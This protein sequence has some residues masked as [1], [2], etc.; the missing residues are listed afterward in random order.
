MLFDTLQMYCKWFIRGPRCRQYEA[1]PALAECVWIDGTGH[2]VY[3]RQRYIA[4]AA[5]HIFDMSFADNDA[6]SEPAAELYRHVFSRLERTLE[7]NQHTPLYLRFV[8][9][10]ATQ[11][12]VVV[13]SA[14][15]LFQFPRF[16]VHLLLSKGHFQ[17][18][19]DLYSS[20]DLREAFVHTTT[21]HTSIRRGGGD[22]DTELRDGAAAVA[23]YG[24]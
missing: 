5:E 22:V 23:S 20:R 10:T 18:E 1:S 6:M 17:T 2:R 16:L 11:R 3:L 9:T 4:E 8:D 24:K 13:Y 19:V 7:E 12:N 15:T 14:V 21:V